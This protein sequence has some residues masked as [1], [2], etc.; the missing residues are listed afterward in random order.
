MNAWELPTSLIVKGRAYD[1]RTDFRVILDIMSAMND[2][3]LFLPDASEGERAM[4]RCEVILKILYKD[5]DLIPE[6]DYPEAYG[7]ALDFIDMGM[8]DDGKRKP[9]TMDWEQDAQI[10]IPA[11]N[12]VYGTEIRAVP[13]LH[14]W[15]FLGSYM[16]IGDCLFSQV[17]NIRQKKAKNKKLEKWEK[18]FYNANKELVTLKKKISEDQKK[19]ID[20]LE[21]WL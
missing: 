16:E 11:V 14:W 19:E 21:K 4:V 5:Y 1:I 10:I 20:D 2:P 8:K 13:Y 12:R 9:H 7:Q 15:T 17:V 3:D 18:D 6:E